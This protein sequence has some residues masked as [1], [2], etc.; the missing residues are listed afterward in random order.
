MKPMDG[1]RSLWAVSRREALLCGLLALSGCSQFDV[2]SQSPEDPSDD[3]ASSVK[4]VGEYARAVG[5]DTRKIEGVA[6][7]TQLPGTGGD[8]PPSAMRIA[9]IDDMQARGVE[10]P[11]QVL[12]SPTTAMVLVV[13]YLRPGIR[14]GDHFDVSVQVPPNDPATSLRG[15]F[16]METRLAD[17]LLISDRV[18]QGRLLGLAAGSILI[19]PAA[20]E[21][22]DKSLLV[23]GRVLGGGVATRDRDLGLMLK[24]VEAPLS[25]KIRHANAIGTAINTRFQVYEAGV[26]QGVAIPHS[27][28]FVELKIVPRYKYNLARYISVV[29]AIALR[30]S[31]TER[32]NRLKL[33]ERQLLDPITSARAA[34][35]LEA[36]GQDSVGILKKGLASNNVEVR[37]YSAEALAY[38]DQPEAA[39]PLA[40]A[41][42]DE[43]AFRVFALAALG[44][45][46]DIEG[47]ENLQ[48]LLHLPSAETRYGAFRALWSTYRDDPRFRGEAVGNNKF[49]YHPIESH[50]PPMIHLTGNFRPEI[51][52][53]GRDHRLMT[54][55]VLEVGKQFM[56]NAKSPAEVVVASFSP[57]GNSDRRVV[58][59][60]VDRIIRAVVELGGTYGDVVQL[61]QLAKRKQVLTSRL[62]VDAL[63]Q[64]GR[65]YVR[66]AAPLVG[67]GGE[68]EDNESADGKL[69]VAS[70]APD[71]FSQVPE[72]SKKAKGKSADSDSAGKGSE[73]DAAAGD[74]KNSSEKA[75]E[76][77]PP[78]KKRW[79]G[80][81]L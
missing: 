49:S 45:M 38:L 57:D 20:D 39:A 30:E 52:M 36:I 13:G 69:N 77:P 80:G 7:V 56:I 3:V 14:K 58:T 54:P 19:D 70:P 33:L 73:A 26:Q 43:P 11:N 16:L 63:P 51:V 64:I 21:S 48:K 46:G 35:V 12:A 65:T 31:G 62:E 75:D 79:L 71:L 1:D 8:P 27:D 67:S 25:V 34:I 5:L 42:E 55:V 4:L 66:A 76:S 47:Y 10:H 68:A 32:T 60:N 22:D 53:F 9:L 59:D 24:D 28:Q 81:I 37:F 41:A 44:A 17:T 61:L 2:N 6:L 78:K 23:K 40:K 15:G 74:A 18:R 50:G 29:R 72:A